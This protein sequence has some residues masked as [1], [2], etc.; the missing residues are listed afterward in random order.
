MFRLVLKCVV[1]LIRQGEEVS[2]RGCF[3]PLRNAQ[4]MSKMITN[5]K[6]EESEK[7]E[8]KDVEVEIVPEGTFAGT[9]EKPVLVK[10]GERKEED[11][12]DQ[13]GGQM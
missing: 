10:E 4:K 13:G 3:A 1:A 12:G 8:T 6:K 7:R 5:K 9:K 2:L 11:T